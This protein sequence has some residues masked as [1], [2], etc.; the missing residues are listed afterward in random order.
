MS[1]LSPFWPDC[2]EAVSPFWPDCAEAVLHTK[3]CTQEQDSEAEQLK[4]I[5]CFLRVPSRNKLWAGRGRQEIGPKAGT[6]RLGTILDD[7][8]NDW[9]ERAGIYAGE[10][11]REWGTGALMSERIR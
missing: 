6:L 11:M 1:L 7:L 3:M 4:S 10:L 9:E 8:A 2:A 5:V